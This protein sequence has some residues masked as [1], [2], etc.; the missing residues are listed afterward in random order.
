MLED[1][2]NKYRDQTTRDQYQWPV[3]RYDEVRDEVIELILGL[4][5]PG[6][7]QAEYP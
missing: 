1:D 3:E 4:Y 5:N 6:M 7:Q 2:M